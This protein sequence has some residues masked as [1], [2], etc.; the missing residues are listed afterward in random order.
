MRR[1]AI[2]VGS[3]SVLLLVSEEQEGHWVP[4]S[5]QTEVTAL[6]EGTKQTGVLSEEAMV[7]TLDAVKRFSDHAHE[8]GAQEVR[9]AAT[10]AARI[11]ENRE[12]F[13]QRAQKQNT[14]IFILTGEQ[15]AQLGFE[16]VVND[17]IFSGY[18]RIS[19]ID[20]GGHST[21]LVT[22]DPQGSTW[23]ILYKRSFPVG[24]LS[25]R[26]TF[27]PNERS[28]GLEVLRGSASID[29]TIGLCY[30]QNA[31]GVVVA[32]GAAG[33]NLIS[34][35]DGLATWMPEKVHGSELQYEEISKYVGSLMP[36]SDEERA[37]ILGMEKG[38][39]KTIHLGALVLERFLFSLRAES[40]FVS[41]RGWRYALLEKASLDLI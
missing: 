3:N 33:T 1:A 16:A 34:I 36:M 40:C 12:D 5:E 41:I 24:T 7:R 15:E 22:A 6:G 19:I 4:I 27:F 35:R 9:I 18:D 25:L 2:D 21:E 8:L 23:N 26:S 28:G 29:E 31:C 13:L 14:P 38:R 10:M 30:R 20:P 17:P 11:A 32:L 37:N 39:E